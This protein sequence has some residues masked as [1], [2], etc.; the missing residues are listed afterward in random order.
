MGWVDG[1]SSLLDELGGAV[2]ARL[3]DHIDLETADDGQTLV[4]R[5]GALVSLV[6]VEGFRSIMSGTAILEHIVAP[7]ETALQSG[8]DSK[9]HQIQVWFEFDPERNAEALAKAHEGSRATASRVGLSVDT[10]LAARETNIS[11]YIGTERLWLVLY[12]LPSALNKT[13]RRQESAEKTTLR[14]HA[15][16]IRRGQDP[17]RAHHFLRNRHRSWVKGLVGEMARV[18]LV[19]A[20]LEVHAAVRG[21]RA[22]LSPRDAGDDWSPVLPGDPVLPSVRQRTSGRTE[23]DILWPPLADQVSPSDAS[24]VDGRYVRLGDRMYAPLVLDIFPRQT[25]LFSQLF[26]RIREKHLP[27]RMSFTMV[28]GGITNMTFRRT[29]ASMLA[30]QAG[31]R[32][33]RQAFESLDAALRS[34][35]SIAVCQASFC[36]WAPANDRPLLQRRAADLARSIEAWGSCQVSEQTGD[37]VGALVSTT[38]GLTTHSLANRTAWPLA[39]ALAMLPWTRPASP[40]SNGSLLLVSPSG[41]LMPIEMFSRRQATWVTLLFAGPGS[42]KSVLMQLMHLALVLRDGITRLPRISILDVGPSSK[43]FIR[44][45]EMRLPPGQRHLVTHQRLRMTE[46]EAVNPFD[47][48]LGARFPTPLEM[49]SL[50]TLLGV[51]LTPVGKE[52]LDDAMPGLIVEV[53]KEMYVRTS[54]RQEP[55]PYQPGV[56]TEVDAELRDLRVPLDEHTTW[57]DVVDSL[58]LAK[59]HHLAAVAQRYAVPVL[60]EA[61]EVARS[62]R[63]LSVYGNTTLAGSSERLI[64][65]FVR[66]LGEQTTVFPNLTRPTRFSLGDARIV[67]LD[68][69]EVARGQGPQGQR[70]AQVMYMI[71]RQMLARDFYIDPDYA[72]DM[73]APADFPLAETCPRQ[74]YQLYHSQRALDVREDYKRLC[75]DEFHLASG[76]PMIVQQVERDIRLGRKY[77]VDVVLASQQMHDFSKTMQDDATTTIVMGAADKVLARDAAEVFGMSG[78]AEVDALSTSIRLPEAPTPGIFLA[79]FKTTHGEFSHLLAAPLGPYEMW[80]FTTSPDDA[81]LRDR[82]TQA[83]GFDHA[84]RVLVRSYPGGS[85]AAEIE[86]RRKAMGV[87]GLFDGEQ[88]SVLTKMTQELVEAAPVLTL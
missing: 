42:G 63:I 37:P 34:N 13:E 46:Q 25:M 15:P 77:R 16:V 67:A 39:D 29:L 68:L 83:I 8:F 45:L 80:A 36:T 38:P 43:G 4:T 85:A 86:A 51:M 33:I 88:G 49:Q 82:L 20:P 76:S 5:A 11:R 62:E 28:G 9:G 47:T 41:R 22:A 27:W 24:E 64:D 71:A 87:R 57:W 72:R 2:R 18:G 73:P 7:L 79:R 56:A 44:L 19:V 55:H 59:R 10:L 6:A 1:I 26:E 74:A 35:T 21:M 3:A 61:A 30:F 50:H 81:Q 66:M 40:F 32:L 53:L 17:L 54:D 70:V 65:A 84:M 31:N 75:Y 23:W 14:K 60:P 78:D 52:A 69:D 48:Q 12:T 58:F